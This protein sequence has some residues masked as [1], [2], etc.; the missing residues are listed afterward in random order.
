MKTFLN[1]FA[2]ALAAIVLL[3]ALV[4][5]YGACAANRVSKIESDSWL[6]VELNG[7]L[8][9]YDPPGEHIQHHCPCQ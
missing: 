4:G 8:P 3:V 1:S 9:E 2:G 5:S 7:A 6:V